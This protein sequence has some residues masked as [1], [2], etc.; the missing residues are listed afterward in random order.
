MVFSTQTPLPALAH[1]PVQLPAD[2]LSGSVHIFV[3]ATNAADAHTRVGEVSFTL[4]E[5][6]AEGEKLSLEIQLNQT[7]GLNAQIQKV[8]GTEKTVVTSLDIAIV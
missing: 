5:A 3:G 6:L 7:N 2:S 1:I 8:K 4:P